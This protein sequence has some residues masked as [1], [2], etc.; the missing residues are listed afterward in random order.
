MKEV[1]IFNPK[2]KKDLGNT[3][4]VGNTNQIVS[5]KEKAI[6][7]I[8]QITPELIHSKYVNKNNKNNYILDIKKVLSNIPSL[9]I[10]FYTLNKNL[11][12][13]TLKPNDSFFAAFFKE[14]YNKVNF[15][16]D[17][18]EDL[19]IRDLNF[20]FA[21]IF[22]YFILNDVK[23]NKDT[24]ILSSDIMKESNRALLDYANAL[25]IDLN[26]YPAIVEEMQLNFE[27]TNV[28]NISKYYDVSVFCM[29][30]RLKEAGLI[31]ID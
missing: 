29:Y 31:I 1:L 11:L 16:I 4:S 20:K 9:N 10:D 19:N 22:A 14:D 25:L 13:L 26:D 7:R 12:G 2:N 6:S 21:Y 30:N 8:K 15:Y 18:D 28:Y 27:D 23:E 24:I 3:K 5:L 17:R